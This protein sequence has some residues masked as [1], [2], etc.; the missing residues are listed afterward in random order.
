MQSIPY[1]QQKAQTPANV[2]SEES[3]SECVINSSIVYLSILLTVFPAHLQT[4]PKPHS[5]NP[6]IS[7]DYYDYVLIS[8][9]TLPF[10]IFLFSAVWHISSAEPSLRKICLMLK[11]QALNSSLSWHG[12]RFW[13]HVIQWVVLFYV[14]MCVVVLTRMEAKFFLLSTLCRRTERVKN[15][16]FT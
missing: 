12:R 10:Q 5:V 14:D 1:F 4:R 2:T 15:E 3:L 9:P 8:S 7:N 16:S 11:F 13:H 6:M